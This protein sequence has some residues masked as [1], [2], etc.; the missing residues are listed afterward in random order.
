[1]RMLLVFL[2]SVC[3]FPLA[4]ASL[5]E[6]CR[7]GYELVHGQNSISPRF[8]WKYAVYDHNDQANGPIRECWDASGLQPAI[9]CRYFS[10]KA[11]IC[12]E[13]AA[14]CDSID[15]Q[16]RMPTSAN[17][18]LKC[19]VLAANKSYTPAMLKDCSQIDSIWEIFETPDKCMDA[20]GN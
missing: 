5:G 12:K 17:Q 4:R 8:A 18:R 2:F 14:V 1:M 3:T 16:N 9:E 6:G 11:Y 19:R 20:N 13:A 10:E 7:E 15:P